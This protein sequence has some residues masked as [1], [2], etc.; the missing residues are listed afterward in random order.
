LTINQKDL[1]LINVG[2]EVKI[3]S[4][5]L[6]KST[7]GKVI[8]IS[9][10]VSEKNKTVKV[11]VLINNYSGIWRPG[12]FITAELKKDSRNVPIVVKKEAIQKFR[13]WD[14][15]FLNDGTQFEA[16]PVQLGQESGDWVEIKSGLDLNQ[17]YVSE[18][19]FLLKAD[20]EKSSASHEH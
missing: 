10:I 14:I 13:D 12:A 9:P 17:N 1:D 11:N 6:Q 8:Y 7:T 2:Q 4:D 19:S 3:T 20:I 18:N 15:V 5:A 16:Q